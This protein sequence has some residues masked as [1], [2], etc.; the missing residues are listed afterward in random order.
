[1]HYYQTQQQAN[2]STKDGKE[3]L[4]RLKSQAMAQ[5]IQDAYVKQLAAKHSV[6]INP[7]TVN[8]QLN[9]VRAQ[10]RLGNNDRVFRD[11][12]SQFWGWNEA[13]FK[14]KLQQQL[15]TQA[16][17]AK[18]DTTTQQRA[19]AAV[20]QLGSG[21]DF[22][23]LAGQISDDA[24]TKGTGGQYPAPLTPDDRE[25]SPLITAEAFKLKAGQTS[26]IINTGYTLEIIKA[27]EVNDGSARIAHIQFNFKPIHD[28][29]KPLQSKT[30]PQEYIK[31]ES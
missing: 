4:K 9:L 28:F 3:Q 10:N 29:V 26:G 24:T 27:I 13:D 17:V 16:V 6:S 7:R 30:P 20:R 25:I 5:V 14:R 11:V 2:F 8:D 18:L 23:Q 12:L 31:V 19:A 15:L 1:M 21:A 22:G